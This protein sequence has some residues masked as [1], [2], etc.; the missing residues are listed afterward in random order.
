M[1]ISILVQF[2]C[3]V[4]ILFFQ[5]MMDCSEQIRQFFENLPVAWRLGAAA[6]RSGLVHGFSLD[7]GKIM[8]RGNK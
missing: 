2:I 1:K 3:A 4:P 5:M 6:K 7:K 8:S